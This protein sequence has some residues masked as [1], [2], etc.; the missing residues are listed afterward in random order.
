M[1]K[2]IPTITAALSCALLMILNISCNS[3][4]NE[5][6]EELP[7]NWSV[8]NPENH[9][10]SLPTTME[11]LTFPAMIDGKE[12]RL[13][14][15]L[16]RPKNT[17]K[18]PLIVFSHGRNGKNPPRDSTMVNWYDAL[19][20]R[21]ASEGYVVVYVVR[22]GYG[23]S[24]GKDSELLDTAVQCGLEAAKDYQAAVEYW[25]GNEFVLPG[26]VVLMGQSQGGWSVLAC[27][28]V[29]IEGV[30]GV[31]NISG[32]TNY[33][34][35]GSGSV[36]A[37]VQDHWVAGCGELGV[38]ARVPSLWIYSENDKAISGPTAERMFM[39]Y[40]KAGAKANMLM[41]PPFGSDGHGIVM[42]PNL[43]M[44]SIMEFFS[45]IGF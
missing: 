12:Y 32:G 39:A 25:S 44:G 23:N 41:L 19:C 38:T 20:L 16:F 14:A 31:V 36:T 18:H 33:L 42:S 7:E 3:G 40:I 22:R 9:S 2:R 30:V 11:T 27:A 21:L 24:E 4:K 15:K 34:S 29:P 13:E 45:A 10:N 17:E 37:A 8:E 5:A 35:M 26:K 6:R 1:K 28:S 43:F